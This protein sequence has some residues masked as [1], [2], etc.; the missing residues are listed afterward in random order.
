MESDEIARAWRV[1]PKPEAH[2]QGWLVYTSDVILAMLQGKLN[3]RCSVQRTFKWNVIAV[4]LRS[5]LGMIQAIVFVCARI[6]IVA[7]VLS[8]IAQYA[9]RDP[10]GFALR[11]CY[12]KARLRSLGQDTLI[13]QGVEI[14]GAE[15][16]EVGH[17]C[18]LSTNVRISAGARVADQDGGE[19]AIGDYSFVGPSSLLS[20][21]GRIRV[22]D[23]V[24]ISSDVCIYSATN[25][26]SDPHQP[27]QLTSMSH[28]APRDRQYVVKGAVEIQ[29]YVTV[30]P[31]TVV[32]PNI[33]LGTGAI[34]HSFCQVSKSFPP[35]SNIVGP[36]RAKQNGWRRPHLR[37]GALIKELVAHDA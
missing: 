28:C 1:L 20:G 31:H 3:D 24:A 26:H 8:P 34:V 32:L 22:G 21:G 25:A 10:I 15:R 12:W 16:V 18:F 35:F 9:G 17:D 14:Y 13:D 11:S 6:P 19:I 29:D 7:W 37:S 4:V 5:C 33:T 30:C 2:K 27:D 23:F 36:G